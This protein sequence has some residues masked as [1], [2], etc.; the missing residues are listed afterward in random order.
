MTDEKLRLELNK[1]I[2]QQQQ[3]HDEIE[4]RRDK[5]ELRREDFEQRS[6]RWFWQK[7]LWLFTARAGLMLAAI[8][9]LESME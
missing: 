8:K 4:L 5:I 1:V 2:V 3:W 7:G 9:V 6:K